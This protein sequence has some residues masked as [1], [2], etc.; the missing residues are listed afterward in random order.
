VPADRATWAYDTLAELYDEDMGASAPGVDVEFYVREATSRARSVLELGCGTGRITL[1]LLRA[2]LGVTAVDRSLP[3]L[4]VLRR[5]ALNELDEPARRRLR[6]EQMDMRSLELGERFEVTLCPYSAFG[7]LLTPADRELAL[8]GVREH[9]APGGNLLLDMFVPDPRLAALPDG[10]P[11]ADYRR[12]RAS[13]GFLERSKLIR[14]DVEARV[15]AIERRY[16]VLDDAGRELESF[17]THN[18]VRY[19]SPDELS[20]E[21][22]SH[23]FVVLELVTDFVRGETAAAPRVAFFRCAVRA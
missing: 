3:M 18:R 16:R 13:G 8:S 17:V 7:Y 15:N 14:K 22:E 2:G 10:Q 21:L 20:A 11:I 23:G 9:L 19:W 6:I 4:D 1:P 5:K 12:K